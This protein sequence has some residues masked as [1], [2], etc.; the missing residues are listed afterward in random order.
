[1]QRPELHVAGGVPAEVGDLLAG[2][3]ERL[4]GSGGPLQPR[5]VKEASCLIQML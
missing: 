2:A 4:A 5:D 1:M 3:M